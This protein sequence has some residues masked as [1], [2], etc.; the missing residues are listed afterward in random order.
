MMS[1][2]SKTVL[3]CEKCG[4]VFKPFHLHDFQ[5]TKCERCGGELKEKKE[6]VIQK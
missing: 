4:F 5:P 6:E 1:G 2:R 3:V